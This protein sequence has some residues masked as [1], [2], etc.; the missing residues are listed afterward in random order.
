MAHAEGHARPEPARPRVSVIIVSFNSGSLLLDCVEAVLASTI[1]V[2]V[3]V[4]D[5]A[6]SD[7]SLEALRAA[8]A[9]EGRLLIRVNPGNLGLAA[10]ANRMLDLARAPWLLFLNPDCLLRPDTLEQM[11]EVVEMQPGVAMAGPLI[12]NEDGSE[13]AGC[14]RREPTPWRS[15]AR[16]LHLSRLGIRHPALADFNLHREPLP[17]TPVCV[18]AISGAFMLVRRAALEQVGPL[19]EGYFLH[20]EDLDWCRRFRDAGHGVLF[21]PHIEVIHHKGV[22]S[23]SLPVRVEWH[24]ARGMLRYFARFHG[25]DHPVPLRWLIVLAI[26]GRFALLLPVLVLRRWRQR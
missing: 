1:P 21:V 22:S 14:R 17:R 5:N 16:V 9:G 25:S 4:S 23:R 24:K 19:D 3:L 13:Q 20:C 15:L 2:E 6:S 12:R 18:D 7:G 10:A 8:K 11:L 26:W